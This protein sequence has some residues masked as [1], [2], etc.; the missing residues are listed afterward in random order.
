M[1]ILLIDN[2]SSL[3]NKLETLLG[4]N[5][6][7]ILW[8]ELAGVMTNKFDFMVLSGGSLFPIAEHEELLHN[9]IE[10]IQKST[11]PIIGICYGSEL[12]I[13][14]FGGTIKKSSSLHKGV[15][16]ITTTAD[17]PIFRD[18]K[19]FKVFESHQWVIESLPPHFTA[20]ARSEHG[21][22]AFKHDHLPIYG[23]QFH[24]EQSVAEMDGDEIFRNAIATF[25]IDISPI[26]V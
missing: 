26:V 2:G 25:N 6:I 11:T 4:E 18:K 15:I 23:F 22:E 21:I 13:R 12:I 24:P 8:N 17:S 3:L 5:V 9:E 16:E 10:L 19:S 14:A 20:L 1:P 7:R